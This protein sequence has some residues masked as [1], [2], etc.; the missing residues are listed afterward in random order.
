MASGENKPISKIIIEGEVNMLNQTNQTNLQHL[1]DNLTEQPSGNAWSAIESQ[2]NVILPTT[3]QSLT[4]VATSSKGSSFF[5]K[6][7]AA[8]LKA[9]AITGSVAVF[10]TA[11]IISIHVF[12]QKTPDK[13]I[14]QNPQNTN[15]LIS[16]D[17]ILT[18][19]NLI[20]SNKA[21]NINNTLNSN[22]SNNN[23]IPTPQITSIPS[24]SF[25]NQS[26]NVPHSIPVIIPT[27][28]IASQ[29]ITE[30]KPQI[31]SVTNQSD[32]VFQN[33]EI[34][35]SNPIKIT[36]PNIFTP[37]FDGYNDLFVIEGIENCTE[38]K[39][40]I[41]N[42]SGKI[43]FQSSGYQNDWNAENCPDGVYIY[44]FIYKVN[45]IEEKMMGKVIIKR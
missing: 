21:Q 38:N 24:E 28:Q 40:I 10:T 23:T 19:S 20:N 18:K 31:S 32:P 5:A 41:K 29:N 3:G 42:N 22:V 6:I 14:S 17:S 27:E 7:A 45:K 30:P 33:Q 4:Q 12:N 36:I 34:E 11:A 2:L 9:A 25:V 39:L 16:S 26:S 1:L 37:N 44:Y 13:I 8:P 15:S 35:F 43:I